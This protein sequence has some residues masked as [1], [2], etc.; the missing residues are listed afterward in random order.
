VN[1]TVET[2]EGGFWQSA[3]E[4]PSANEQLLMVTGSMR[5]II[6]RAAVFL[7]SALAA[8]AAIILL[9]DLLGRFAPDRF[10]YLRQRIIECDTNYRFLEKPICH[11]KKL[12]SPN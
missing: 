12:P 9:N 8:G 6:V 7:G 4:K 1:A 2:T 3:M 10:D 5:G 11:D